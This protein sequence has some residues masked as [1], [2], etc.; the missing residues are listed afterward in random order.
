M[1]AMAFVHLA[2]P[3][4]KLRGLIA[5]RKKKK[6]ETPIVINLSM[7]NVSSAP[8]DFTSITNVNA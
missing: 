4:L 6:E 3:D 7:V 5:S 1:R 8:L 2:T